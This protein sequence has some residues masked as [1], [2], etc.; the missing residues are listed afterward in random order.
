MNRRPAFPRTSLPAR[1][2][3]ATWLVVALLWAQGLGAW[4]HT[5]HAPGLKAPGAAGVVAAASVGYTARDHSAPLH[6]TANS[7][8]CRLLDQLLLTDGLA[9]PAAAPA[10]LP[11]LLAPAMCTPVAQVALAASRPYLARAPPAS[12]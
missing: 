5:V 4:H 3:W 8:D 10:V 11:A 1:R 9:T 7:A 2:R 6:H 12:S